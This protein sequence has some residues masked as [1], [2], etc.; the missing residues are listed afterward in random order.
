MINSLSTRSLCRAAS[1]LLQRVHSA[2]LHPDVRTPAAWQREHPCYAATRRGLAVA[3]VVSVVSIASA[4]APTG[5]AFS[6]TADASAGQAR[7]K[8]PSVTVISIST[9]TKSFDLL[10]STQLPPNWTLP[11]YN[12]AAWDG[13]TPVS[14][15][16][17]TCVSQNIGA[18]HNLPTYWG[19]SPTETYLLRQSFILPAAKSYSGSRITVGIDTYV[20]SGSTDTIYVNGTQVDQPSHEF[21]QS[22]DIGQLLVAGRNVLAIYAN[23]ARDSHTRFNAPCSAA[24]FRINVVTGSARGH[25]IVP[26][27]A[28]KVL[29]FSINSSTRSFDLLAGSQPPPNWTSPIY[30]DAAWQSMRPVTADVQACVNQNVGAWNTYPSYWGQMPTEPYLLRHTFYLPRAKGYGGSFIVVGVD[31]YNFNGAANTIFVNGTQVDQPGHEFLRAYDIGQLLLPGKNVLAVYASPSADSHSRFGVPCSAATFRINAVAVQPGPAPTVP[32]STSRVV[33][34]A[35]GPRTKSLDLAPGTQL[36]TNWMEVRYDDSAW[37]GLQHV[38]ADVQSCV[39]A[40]HR[41]MAAAAGILGLG[42]N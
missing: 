25:V 13:M 1:L 39:P 8:A 10:G 18:W 27:T 14:A 41:C 19:A 42:S 9:R 38:T 3:A 7:S 28:G 40:E 37:T 34:I 32:T 12:D 36:P 17:R 4:S 26:S 15:D 20:F 6:S 11:A 21:L 30:N 2:A 22:Y 16:V 23:P 33:R 35:I 5:A 31:T 24:T 29:R